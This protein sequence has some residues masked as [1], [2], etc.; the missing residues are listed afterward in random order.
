MGVLFSQD[1]SMFYTRNEIRDSNENKL[2][3]KIET[4]SFLKN[5]EY[6]DTLQGWTGIGFMLQPKLVYQPSATTMVEAGYFLEKFSGRSDF[7]KPIPLFRVRQK[8]TNSLELVFG[9]LYGNLEH[10]LGEPVFRFD[11][12]YSD[13]VEYG[14]QFLFNN[15]YFTND[16][17]INW[18]KFIFY[19]DPFKEEFVLGNVSN[20]RYKINEKWKI[21]VPF[22]YTWTHAGGQIDKH[23]ENRESMM[24]L[25]NKMTG[26]ELIFNPGS[27]FLKSIKM[28]YSYYHYS[29]GANP[30]EGQ[31]NHQLFDKGYGHYLKTNIDFGSIKL[32]LGYWKAHNF[33]ARRGE[34][35]FQSIFEY[36]PDDYISNKTLYTLKF[37]Y[38][39]NI[40]DNIIFSIRSDV[41]YRPDKNNT[42]FSYAFYFVY[43]DRFLLKKVKPLY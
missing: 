9:Q 32:M 23:D 16:L 38:D 21:N 24:S 26:S 42:I 39:K 4:T 43:N 10:G 2:F 25:N 27:K 35:I 19:N 20:F 41:Y 40:K 14:I 29:A 6:F 7:Y 3:L 18:E 22:H 37:I 11:R 30:P 13:Y 1:N 5:N 34:Y 8:L 15:K 28:S 33:I 36:L 17:W 12:Y 31:K